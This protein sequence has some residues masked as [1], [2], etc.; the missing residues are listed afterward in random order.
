MP[1]TTAMASVNASTRA[2]SRRSSATSTGSGSSTPS[3]ART[4]AHAHATDAAAPRTPSTRPST[5]SCWISRPRL[6]PTA[7]RTLISR[8]RAEARASSMPATLAQAMSSTRPTTP[9]SPAAPSD[10]TPPACGTRSRTSSEGTAAMLRPLLVSGLASASWRRDHLDVGV[11]LGRRDAVAQPA[12]HEHPPRAAALE[13]GAS[14]RRGHAESLMPTGSTS[15]RC[16]TGSHSSGVSSGTTPVNAGRRH[17]DDRVRQAAQRQAAAD[18]A[19][20][21]AELAPPHPIR[22]HD[23]PLGAGSVVGRREQPSELRLHAEQREV[24][25]RD[26]LAEQ[27]PASGRRG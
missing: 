3:R 4:I 27:R 8:R 9:I 25:R 16:A 1:V 10:S 21:G 20:V 23:D 26:D 6:A 7:S 13:A 5:T 14:D 17:A 22:E 19:R 24:V 15:S 12:L 2:S 11:G 18:D